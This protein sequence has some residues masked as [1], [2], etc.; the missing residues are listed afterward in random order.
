LRWG[1]SMFLPTLITGGLA[2]LRALPRVC[3]VACPRVSSPPASSTESWGC[4]MRDF[5]VTTIDTAGLPGMIPGSCSSLRIV[6]E[7][8]VGSNQKKYSYTTGFSNEFDRY[9]NLSPQANT[10]SAFPLLEKSWYMR[11][12]NGRCSLSE[13]VGRTATPRG[14]RLRRYISTTLSATIL[15]FAFKQGSKP[16]KT[17]RVSFYHC[18]RVGISGKQF[19][20]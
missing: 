10:E 2:I 6:R 20:W 8:G 14:T 7:E 19:S 13:L 1:W 4:R 3:D 16:I 18:G 12:K 9:A 11:G 5:C 15:S 17:P